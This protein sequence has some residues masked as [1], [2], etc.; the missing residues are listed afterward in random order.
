MGSGLRGGHP[1]P[2]ERGPDG[3]Q[4]QYREGKIPLQE[5]SPTVKPVFGQTKGARGIDRFMRQGFV[6]CDREW[7]LINLSNNLL[8]AW[9]AGRARARTT[10]D[11]PARAA[12]LAAPAG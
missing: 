10:A 2:R 1:F 9:R 4:A 12:V 8:K 7:K 6:A 5:R 11:L 3:G